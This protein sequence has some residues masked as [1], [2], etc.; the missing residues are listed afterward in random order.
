MGFFNKKQPCAE[1]APITAEVIASRYSGE[2][3]ER[4]VG[5]T[6]EEK[7]GLQAKLKS[8]EAQLEAMKD[9][10]AKL[11]SAEVFAEQCRR[12]R[13]AETHKREQVER[14]IKA[15]KQENQRSRD[16]QAV[17]QTQIDK[18]ERDHEAR[19]KDVRN[20]LVYAMTD[21][22]IY[23]NGGWSKKHVLDFIEGFLDYV[24]KEEGEL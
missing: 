10:K 8:V 22:L 19:D 1:I 14:E 3:L 11:S 6:Y 18:L 7:L 2:E 21:A 24:P 5:E 17:L 4:M 13:D 15:V 12:E 9:V 23:E 20:D 16:R